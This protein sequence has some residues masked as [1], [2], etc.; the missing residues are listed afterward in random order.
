[1]ELKTVGVLL[2][3]FVTVGAVVFALTLYAFM[4]EIDRNLA[5]MALYYD[6]L[7]VELYEANATTDALIMIDSQAKTYCDLYL[8]ERRTLDEWRYKPICDV[9]YHR[10][11]LFI[12]CSLEPDGPICT[13]AEFVKLDELLII[14]EPLGKELVDNPPYL[15]LAFS[16]EPIVGSM[17]CMLGGEV[18]PC[19][20]T[21]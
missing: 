16:E 18:V 11:R 3:L 12:W 15:G 2:G 17:V 8:A 9:V 5:Y 13:D 4:V 19:P 20:S 10:S 6:S 14:A 21:L 1:M 7:G